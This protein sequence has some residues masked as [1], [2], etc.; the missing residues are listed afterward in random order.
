M[1]HL[2]WLPVLALTI[3]ALAL[4]S[5]DTAPT[6]PSASSTAISSANVGNLALAPNM[7]DIAHVMFGNEQ[8]G[9]GYDP[10]SGHDRSWHGVDRI[11]PHNVVIP[12]GGMVH[13]EIHAFHQAAIYAPGTTP[14][15]IEADIASGA[16]TL[17]DLTSPI[18]IPNFLIDDPVNRLAI[19]PF[20]PGGELEWSPP[21]GTFDEPG[22]YL[23]ICTVT[24][25]FFESK[26]YGYII[27]K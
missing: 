8:A 22:V 21:E 24:F 11:I 13:F 12:V 27:V 5:C 19:S 26:M 23:M 17:V 18:F 7:P 16:A 2:V 14:E 10:P 9:T 1:K 6:E 25:H 20:V 3:L 4:V 15:D